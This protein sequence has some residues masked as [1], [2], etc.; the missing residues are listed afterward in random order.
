[1]AN[2]KERHNKGLARPA[3]TAPP[4][5]KFI[6]CIC[7]SCGKEHKVRMYWTGAKSVK[8]RK[9]CKICKPLIDERTNG[10]ISMKK[11]I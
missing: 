11:E 2:K 1:M 5:A 6:P 4:G 8:P 10:E 7:P 3:A 9:Y